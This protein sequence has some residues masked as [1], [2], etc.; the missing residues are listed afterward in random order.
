MKRIINFYLKKLMTKKIIALLLIVIGFSISYAQDD[1]RPQNT[2]DNFSLEGALSLFKKANSL[3]KFEKMLNKEN[4]NV[5]NLDLNNDG[6]I[7]YIMVDDIQEGNN[8]VIVLSTYINGN[9]KQDIATIGIEK[10]GNESATLQIE[11]DQDLYAQ[12][13]FVEPSDNKD[14][15]SGGK[16]GPNV[17]EI[18]TTQLVVNV[19]FWPSVRFL[20]AP[21]Y[22]A[23]HSPWRW[24]FYP[25]W[26]R[27]WRPYQFSVFYGNCAPFR[28][29]YRRVPMRRVMVA[30][31]MYAPRRH[32]ST[33]VVHNR[34]SGPMIRQR[35]RVRRHGRNRR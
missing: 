27:P 10:N 35:G 29:Y 8:H 14:S 22:I 31:N 23:W 32:F 17:P 12:N 9:E 11:G 1:D 21:T 4:N 6:D 24:G 2:G 19:W 34:R 7:D 28:A 20:Y 33:F 5:N 15:Y 13:T 26:W 16:G 30:H 25:R 3:H 18:I